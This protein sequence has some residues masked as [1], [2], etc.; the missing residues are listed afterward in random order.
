[1]VVRWLPL[2]D[3][4]PPDFGI[5]LGRF[6]GYIPERSRWSWCYLVLLDPA[7]PSARWCSIDTAWESDLER[8]FDE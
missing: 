6:Y 4:V 8:D 3:F 2:D 7:S 5:V 1:M